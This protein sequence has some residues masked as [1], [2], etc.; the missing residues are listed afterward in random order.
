MQDSALWIPKDEILPKGSDCATV[1]GLFS[2]KQL[3]ELALLRKLIMRKTAKYKEMRYSLLLAFHN[4]LSLI[5]LTY[6]AT[7]IG[8]GNHFGFYYRYKLEKS[9]FFRYKRDI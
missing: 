9:L 7:K 3:T 4:I 8:G 2:S 6:R 5:N 1:L